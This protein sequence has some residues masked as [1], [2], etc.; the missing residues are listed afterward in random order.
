MIEIA[1][2]LNFWILSTYNIAEQKHYA[3]ENQH[4]TENCHN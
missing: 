3:I 1:T 2:T 4:V